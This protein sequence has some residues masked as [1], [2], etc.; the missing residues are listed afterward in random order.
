MEMMDEEN[1][2]N[3]NYVFKN[4]A[5]QAK[6]LTLKNSFLRR[7]KVIVNWLEYNARDNL[8]QIKNKISS[9]PEKCTNWEHTLHQLHSTSST[10]QQQQ[11]H[12]RD[13]VSE[14]DPD[15]PIRQHKHLHDLDQEDEY[16]IMEYIFCYLRAGDLESASK[17]CMKIGHV[18]RAAT[19]E[20]FKLFNDHN[21]THLNSDDS[22]YNNN[23]LKLNDGNPNRDL[24]R[25]VVSKMIDN[26]SMSVYEKAV[27]GTLAGLTRP[28]LGVCKTYYDYIWVFFK[29][30]YN[31]LLEKQLR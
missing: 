11:Q 31:N 7:V 13:F 14:L 26:D 12:T 24:W 10:Q 20:G 1:D 5:K 8:V 25:L 23:K 6:R 17:L 22:N 29:A 3:S 15:A 21:Y 27:Y 18:W 2:E 9:M 30:L 16:L 4:E 28:V 19:F